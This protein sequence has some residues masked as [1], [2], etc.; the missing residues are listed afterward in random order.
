MHVNISHDRKS[1][2]VGFIA[3]SADERRS[4][5]NLNS[6]LREGS[7]RL[8]LHSHV[9]DSSGVDRII[10]ESKAPRKKSKRK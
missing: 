10:F 3:E 4:L 2:V 7:K 9:E 8:E 6:S 1:F 5:A